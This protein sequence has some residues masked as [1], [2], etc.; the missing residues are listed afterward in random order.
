[1]S[2]QS[3]SAAKAANFQLSALSCQLLEL[4]VGSRF[5]RLSG[6]GQQRI[7]AAREETKNY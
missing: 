2:P 7:F 4:A 5:G 6:D 1:M 3:H